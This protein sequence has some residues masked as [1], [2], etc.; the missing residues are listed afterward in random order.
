MEGHEQDGLDNVTVRDGVG[1]VS[2]VM[3]DSGLGVVSVTGTGTD[4]SFPDGY[5]F[6]GWYDENNVRVS[7][8]IKYVL[9]DV[10]LTVPH[11]YTAR[12]E[13]RVNYHAATKDNIDDFDS[14]PYAQVWHTYKEKFHNLQDVPLDAQDEFVG[15]Y[16]GGQDDGCDCGNAVGASDAIVAPCTV[17]AH[18]DGSTSYYIIVKSDFPSAAT[19]TNGGK[20]GTGGSFWV[21]AVTNEGYNFLFWGAEGSNRTSDAGKPKSDWKEISANSKYQPSGSAYSTLRWYGFEAHFSADVV[22]HFKDINSV[23]LSATRHYS[24]KVFLDSNVTHTYQYPLFGSTISERTDISIASPADMSKEGYYFAGWLDKNSVTAEEWDYIYGTEGG[25]YSVNEAASYECNSL[26]IALA[27]VLSD[28]AVVTEPMDLYPVYVK[29]NIITD[30]DISRED[31]PD[32]VNVP[33][34]PTYSYIINEDGKG[35]VTVTADI[36]T[37]IENSSEELFEVTH[38]TLQIDDGDIITLHPDE[39]G[40]ITYNIKAG[41]TY[42]FVAYYKPRVI[43]Y[44]NNV[45]SA[46]VYTRN[47]GDLL[48]R[49]PMPSY[50][51]SPDKVFV[52]WTESVPEREYHTINYED[53]EKQEIKLASETQLVLDSMEFYAVYAPLTIEA[54]SNIDDYLTSKNVDITTVRYIERPTVD[55]VAIDAVDKP[56]GQYKFI[57]WYT[58]YVNLNNPGTLVTTN[59]NFIFEGS[60]AFNSVVYTAV[61][62]DAY[63]INYYGVD[64]T[65][66]YTTTV[67]E[68]DN[69]SFV[70]IVEDVVVPIDHEA[71][72]T[73]QGLLPVNSE[74]LSWRWDNDGTCMEWNSF[75]NTTVE[76][77]M[78][79]ND[80]RVMNLYPIVR[81]LTAFD[82]NG[83]EIISG[84]DESA[85]V[86][87]NKDADGYTARLNMEYTQPV[88]TVHIEDA[89]YF[90]TGSTVSYIADTP[91]RLYSDIK[92]TSLKGIENTNSD[93]DA[94]FVLFGTLKIKK[95]GVSDGDFIFTLASK[96][97][98]NVEINSFV[99]SAEETVSVVLPLGEYIVTENTAWAWRYKPLSQEV[100]L[101]LQSSDEVIEVTNTYSNKK[102]F[103]SSTRN[104]NE[105]NGGGES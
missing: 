63:E 74:L 93:G 94:N 33:D 47:S 103:D 96:A 8:S 76:E 52:G 49:T 2:A 46:L 21:D 30:T 9:E 55:K 105:F 90:S 79:A 5:R 11:T 50:A 7:K 91:V 92:M 104:K 86:V 57:G 19:V 75:C 59:K 51:V 15:W 64:G 32:A 34:I 24:E 70:K 85:D 37:P 81:S 23:P 22:F 12:F 58:D 62:R 66:A 31:I 20:P 44:H 99:I 29:I 39:N 61:Y 102:W 25:T 88:F 56:Y 78:K 26:N 77:N 80:T 101:S 14:A 60:E 97:E 13:Y 40:Q 35:T 69:R 3:N 45:D 1:S 48:G 100:V 17:H 6:I 38:I 28:D 71:F 16:Y 27:N 18:V 68:G 42:K 84:V 72:S 41:P 95:T 89:Y 4:G 87:L 67:L 82:A 43:V 73:V 53:I 54:N 36:D 65:I 10:N 83:T 98:P